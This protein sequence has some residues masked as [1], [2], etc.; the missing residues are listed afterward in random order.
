MKPEDKRKA[1]RMKE[2]STKTGFLFAP[3]G[4]QRTDMGRALYERGG[5]YKK[6]LNDVRA[7]ASP[8]R[9]SR[10]GGFWGGVRLPTRPRD[11]RSSRKRTA[12]PVLGRR[13]D[14]DGAPHGP[15]RRAVPG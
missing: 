9:R 5:I 10:E 11:G 7:P 4:W 14:V 6:V 8:H 13:G 12:G 3:V 1:Q 2:A 15:P